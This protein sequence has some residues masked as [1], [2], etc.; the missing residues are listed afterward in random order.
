MKSENQSMV[1]L[2]D[3]LQRANWYVEILS[4]YDIPDDEEAV[5]AK[6]LAKHIHKELKLWEEQ[7]ELATRALKDEY[8]MRRAVFA[9]ILERLS[10]AKKALA[11]MVGRYDLRKMQEQRRLMQL[12]AEQSP[13]QAL[14]TMKHARNE[15]PPEVSG[16]QTRIVFQAVVEDVSL[17][18]AEYLV[19]V[20]DMEKLQA[21]VDAGKRDIPGVRIIEVGKTTFRG[22]KKN[23]R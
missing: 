11:D 14:Q 16:V 23:A 20:V 17:V 21:D 7:R 8:D 10:A 1:S 3:G 13:T 18:P 2:S 4:G 12:A 22:G 5:A 6:T 19:T 9:P 15:R